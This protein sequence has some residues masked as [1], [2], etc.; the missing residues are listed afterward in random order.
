MVDK[1]L[2]V[3]GVKIGLRDWLCGC[4]T[5]DLSPERLPCCSAGGEGDTLVKAVTAGE[6]SELGLRY[7]SVVGSARAF[8]LFAKSGI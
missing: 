6:R 1:H 8:S 2:V 4:W 5:A 7:R 3:A